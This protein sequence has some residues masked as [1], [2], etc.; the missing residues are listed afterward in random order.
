MRPQKESTKD[1]ALD[2]NCHSDIFRTNLKLNLSKKRNCDKITVITYRHWT[3]TLC[4]TEYWLKHGHFTSV[5]MIMNSC[6][7]LGSKIISNSLNHNDFKTYWNK[8]N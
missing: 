5:V 7:G 3:L 8:W 6:Y 2:H 4:N 1:D